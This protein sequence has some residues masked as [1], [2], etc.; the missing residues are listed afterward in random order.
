MLSRVSG[1]NGNTQFILNCSYIILSNNQGSKFILLIIMAFVALMAKIR[2]GSEP[3]TSV[4]FLA[5]ARTKFVKQKK[6]KQD[7]VFQWFQ[8]TKP[9]INMAFE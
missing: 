6:C 2:Q 1:L 7:P 8:C 4:L 5:N 9:I 3:L